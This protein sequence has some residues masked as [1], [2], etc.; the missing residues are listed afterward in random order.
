MTI[1]GGHYLRKQ[2]HREGIIQLLRSCSLPTGWPV[3]GIISDLRISWATTQET[4][5]RS[6]SR[7]HE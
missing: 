6:P 4:L 3:E 1:A 7:S 5:G 2:S